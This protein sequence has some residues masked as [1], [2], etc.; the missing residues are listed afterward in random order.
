MGRLRGAGQGPQIFTW[1]A[2]NKSGHIFWIEINTR[3]AALDGTVC[4]LM[5]VRDITERMEA[6]ETQR[7]LEAQLLQTQKLE[8]LGVLAGGIAHDFNNLLL[9][10]LGNLDMANLEL[11]ADS[12]GREYLTEMERA[13]R[14]AADLCRQMLAYAGKG[15]TSF[16]PVNLGRLIKEMGHLMEVSVTKKAALHYQL[17]GLLPAVNADATQ[18]QQV[19]M[20]LIVNASEAMGERNGRI[21]IRAGTQFCDH[22]YLA[23][24]Y[25]GPT[26]PEGTYVFLDVEDD[27]CG[28]G[29]EMQ[30][31]VFDPFFSTK[32]AGRGLGLATVFGIVRSHH[33]AIKLDSEPGRGTTFRVLVPALAEPAEEREETPPPDQDWRGQ[34]TVL[35]VDDDEA[36]RTLSRRA[37]RQM[38]FNVVSAADGREAL[39]VYRASLGSGSTGEIRCVLLDLTMPY[40]DG[41]QAFRLL[42]ELRTDLPIVMTSGFSEHEVAPRFQGQLVR[43]LQK[44]YRAADLRKLMRE[45]LDGT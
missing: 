14:R 6:E 22:T 7:R 31:K 13:S 24:T 8:S 44:P 27:G 18:M 9:V 39:S 36:V 19:I 35:V 25:L 38:G 21:T 37:L 1:Q 12:P 43:F 5:T 30:Q 23:S 41:E 4:V 40:M 26:L 17:P 32:F 33:G 16:Q 20:N 29:V 28:M 10:I 2:R 45:L 3:A 34:G 15:Q 42:R 11:P